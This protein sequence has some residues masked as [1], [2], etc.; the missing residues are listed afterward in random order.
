MNLTRYYEKELLKAQE[1]GYKIV[2]CK[3]ELEAIEI[4]D[5][6]RKGKRCAQCGM[7]KNNK[8]EFIPFVM[9]KERKV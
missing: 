8:G 1:Q 4:K 2:K 3:S 6:L 9:T 5:A 7:I